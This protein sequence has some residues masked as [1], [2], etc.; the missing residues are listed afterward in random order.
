MH[1]FCGMI[2]V[3]NLCR[4]ALTCSRFLIQFARDPVQVAEEAAALAAA[5]VAGRFGNAPPAAE[6]AGPSG[7]PPINNSRSRLP[8]V[9]LDGKPMGS[10][11]VQSNMYSFALR[12]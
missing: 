10:R 3:G 12:A 8:R 9:R 5:S 7:R 4:L 2:Y 11:Y 1:T 6:A